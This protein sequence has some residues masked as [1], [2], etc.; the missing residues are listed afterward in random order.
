MA[1]LH[2]NPHNHDDSDS[3]ITNPPK[4]NLS[5]HTCESLIGKNVYLHRNVTEHDTIGLHG[6]LLNDIAVLVKTL[7]AT[8]GGLTTEKLSFCGSSERC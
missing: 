7:N 5:I 8:T 2:N 6:S 3:Q 4:Q 1:L